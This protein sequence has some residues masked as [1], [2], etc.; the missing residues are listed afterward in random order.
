MLLN[1]GSVAI[2]EGK[3]WVGSVR[4]ESDRMQEILTY[5]REGRTYISIMT[6]KNPDGELRGQLEPP[7]CLE[8]RLTGLSRV[9][10]DG[11]PINPYGFANVLISPSEKS[12]AALLQ[13]RAHV[14]VCVCVCM[15]YTSCQGPRVLC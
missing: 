11:L 15:V 14:C 9:G 8:A 12:Y 2:S 6:E 10:S 7:T 4:L 5:M 13:V 1:L 3:T